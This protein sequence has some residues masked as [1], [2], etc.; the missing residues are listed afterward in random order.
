MCFQKDG[1]TAQAARCIKSRIM[2]KVID[3]II[4]IYTFEQQCFVLKG[5]F[6][7]QRLKYNVHTIGI[8]QSLSNNALYEHKC[9]GNINKIYR[10]AG[11]CDDQKKIKDILEAAMVYTP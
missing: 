10:Q 4:S 5:M 6:Q 2:T 3:S 11:K 8:Y 9:I 7:S 1:K